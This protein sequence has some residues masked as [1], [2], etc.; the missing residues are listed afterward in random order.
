MPAMPACLTSGLALL[1]YCC[2]ACHPSSVRL[3]TIQYMTEEEA[4]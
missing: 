3:G 4:E 1:T 2:T